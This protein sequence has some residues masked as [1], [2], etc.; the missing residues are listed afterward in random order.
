MYNASVLINY[1]SYGANNT[2]NAGTEVFIYRT[3]GTIPASGVLISGDVQVAFSQ[4]FNVTANGPFS[5][6]GIIYDT[7]LTVGIPYSY[8]LAFSTSAGNTYTMNSGAQLQ[9]TEAK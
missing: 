2:A 3:T 7:T 4:F 6:T 8:Y 5:V 9:L 1:F